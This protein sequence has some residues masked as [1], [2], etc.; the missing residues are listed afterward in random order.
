M[1]YGGL[2][3][4]VGF[5]LVKMVERE[6]VPTAH[7]FVTTVLV[8]VMATV[9]LQG[10]TIKPLVDILNVDKA[11]D[12]Q[13]TLMEEL[14]SEFLENLMPGIEVI[15]GTNGKHYFNSLLTDL[16]EK[17]MMK[18]FTR[19]DFASDMT[20]LFESLALEEH[21]LN[22]YGGYELAKQQSEQQHV[23]LGFVDE[24]TESLPS[25]T[26]PPTILTPRMKAK[27]LTVASIAGS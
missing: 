16:D 26:P 9:W 22:L 1:A 17:Y 18:W 23:N 6:V 24:V 21:K 7:M 3:G 5:S 13:P 11:T 10:S 19:G 25:P 12:E 15:I 20:K 2:R 14:H 4:G 27:I 8:V